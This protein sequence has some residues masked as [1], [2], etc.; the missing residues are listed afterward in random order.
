MVTYLGGGLLA[1]A[2][3]GLAQG[4]SDENVALRAVEDQCVGP[5]RAGSVPSEE[6]GSRFGRTSMMTS[7]NKA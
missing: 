6:S 4:S 7:T 5:C 1:I 2:P 3:K